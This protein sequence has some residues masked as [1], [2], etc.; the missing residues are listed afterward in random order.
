MRVMM[1]PV[2]YHE[3]IVGVGLLCTPL[4]SFMLQYLVDCKES[5]EQFYTSFDLILMF[6]FLIMTSLVDIN[7]CSE[8][9]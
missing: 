5:S 4:L 1:R 2:R 9:T 6:E 3:L 7:V 8:N